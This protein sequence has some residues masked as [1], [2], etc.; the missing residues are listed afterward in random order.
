MV[1]STEDKNKNVAVFEVI[2]RERPPPVE[3]DYE[4]LDEEIFVEDEEEFVSS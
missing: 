2:K 3:P 1:V 4:K